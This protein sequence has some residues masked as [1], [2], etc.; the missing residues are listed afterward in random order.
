MLAL[1]MGSAWAISGPWVV[2]ERQLNVYTGVDAQRLER[3]QV[4][5]EGGPDVIDVGEGLSTLGFKGIVTLGVA[6]RFD[7]EAEIPWY[8]T[9][10]NRP[11]SALCDALG[12]KACDTTQGLGVISVRGKLLVLD[13]IAGAP[14]TAS[15]LGT[16]RIGMFTH[17]T[18]ARITNLGEGTQDLGLG[19]SV[20]RDGVVGG[21]GFFST[22]ADLGFRYRF[23]NT[24]SY[25]NLQ[26][27]RTV[28][29]EEYFGNA[30][31]IVSPRLRYGFGA[32]VAG[33]WRPRGVDFLDLDLTDPDRLAAL[34]VAN[35]R[36][37]G[38]LIVRAEKGFS[39][40]LQVQHTVYASNNPYVT[41]VTAGVSFQGSLRKD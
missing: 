15:V 23:P 8:R 24:R 20:G 39:A 41:V 12:L 18:R 1:W 7:L 34:R 2:G 6:S 21:Q 33:F 30:E 26:G 31:L 28:P 9:I 3:L 16:G 40:S 32:L 29:G 38:T 13:Q 17:P 37:G 19:V 14:V 5:G 25:P 36:A 22:Y 35:V 4:K 27:D 11:D 10:A